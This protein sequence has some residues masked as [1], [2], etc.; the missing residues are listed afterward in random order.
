MITALEKKR[1][2]HY[3]AETGGEV[4]LLLSRKQQILSNLVLKEPILIEGEIMTFL[5]A[6]YLFIYLFD[7]YV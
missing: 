6:D 4:H 5:M 7:C 2:A 1:Q 3:V